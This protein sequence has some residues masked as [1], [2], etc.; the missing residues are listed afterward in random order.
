MTRG[1]ITSTSPV[2]LST[3]LP[4]RNLTLFYFGLFLYTISPTTTRPRQDYDRRRITRSGTTI[5][6]NVYN[7]DVN[8]RRRGNKDTMRKINILTRSDNIRTNRLNTDN[9]ILRSRSLY[10]LTT[11]NT[12]NMNT[13]FRR[14]VRFFIYSL[15]QL[16]NATTT[17]IFSNFRNFINRD[18]SLP[19][20]VYLCYVAAG[21]KIRERADEGHF[22]YAWALSL[23]RSYR[24]TR[25]GMGEL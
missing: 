20:G 4:R 14:N 3:P 5:K 23:Q 25:W 19:W 13:N 12:N 10:T 2:T 24:G 6:C 22:Y 15:L 8:R 7:I 11:R 9:D 16:V 17:T 21:T 1:T 18:G